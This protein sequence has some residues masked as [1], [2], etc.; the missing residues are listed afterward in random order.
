MFEYDPQVTV[1]DMRANNVKVH[2][3]MQSKQELLSRDSFN[4]VDRLANNKYINQR[5]KE[6]RSGR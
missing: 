5:L 3:P 2:K 4:T 6:I 1:S